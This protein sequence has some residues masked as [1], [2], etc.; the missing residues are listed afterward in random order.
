MKKKIIRITTIPTSLRVLLK[1][2]LRFMN[3]YYDV[4]AVTSEGKDFDEMLEEQ[5]VIGY[6]VNMTRKIT[7]LKDLISLFK[8]VRLFRKEKP[9]IVHTHTPKAGILGMLAAWVSGVPYRLHTVAG[10]PW[11]VAKGNRR[12]LLIFVEKLTYSCA[13][14]VYPNSFEM[15]RIIGVNKLINPKKMKVIGNGSSN[16]IDLNF[17]SPNVLKEDKIQIRK[18]LNLPATVFIFCFVGRMVKDKGVNELVQAFVRLY[19]KCTDVHL[20]LVGPFEKEL[21][22][23]RPEVEKTLLTHP[24]IS[25][26]GHQKDVRPFFAV[27]DALVFP[28]YRE[29]FPNVVMQ[30]GAMGLPSIVTDING[31]NEIIM[32]GKN[33]IIIPPQNETA[34]YDAMNYFFENRDEVKRM[35]ANARG[36]IAGRYE[37]RIVWNALLKEYQSLENT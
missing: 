15:A 4:I 25:F 12:R 21:N 28:S 6:K 20:L 32:K 18:R 16:G 30:A 14:Q 34:L 31:C 26:Q 5:D 35:A 11:L 7:P 2:Q 9:F 22:P 23:L 1:N 29:G 27:S 33:G 17:F 3:S 36:M 24:A 10:L 8:L 37:Q 13:T 19:E